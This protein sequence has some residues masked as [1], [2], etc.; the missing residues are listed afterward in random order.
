MK[1]YAQ[2]LLA[3]EEQ[4]SYN[5]DGG[6]N[7]D[8]YGKASTVFAGQNGSRNQLGRGD[9]SRDLGQVYGNGAERATKSA[10][11]YGTKEVT[12]NSGE[13]TYKLS[14][15]PES[16]HTDA[17]RQFQNTMQE[18]GIDSVVIDKNPVAER[19]GKSKTIRSIAFAAPD[20]SVAVLNNIAENPIEVAAHEAF[21]SYFKQNDPVAQQ[22]YQ[23]VIEEIDL[24]AIQQ[25][26][27]LKEL[28][29]PML[30]RIMIC[31]MMLIEI[32]FSMKQLLIFTAA[33]TEIPLKVITAFFQMQQGS[34]RLPMNSPPM[35]S[36]RDN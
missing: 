5:G 35:Q 1:E 16:S 4:N 23:T 26:Y 2:N 29:Q 30:V 15:V 32:K 19:N 9:P 20:G 27:F 18:F 12:I 8:R 3:Q 7:N 36:S 6:E 25:M 22:L 21:H 33:F 28:Q 17:A 14:V 24:S 34:N 13:T 11:E 10:E 31:R